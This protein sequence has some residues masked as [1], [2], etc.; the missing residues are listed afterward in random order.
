MQIENNVSLK[1]FNTFN[2]DVTAKYFADV[3][4]LSELKELLNNK[5]Y[6]TERR[7]FL[8]GGSNILFTKDFAGIIIK[9]NNSKIEKVYETD[10][11][12][13]IK[14]D[15][16]VEWDSFVKYSVDN[17]LSG[18]E[19][20]SLIPGCV[21]AAPIQNIGA[22]GVEVKDVIESVNIILLKNT[23]EKTL[24]NS[25]C[26]FQY[27]NSIFKSELKDKFVI[28][29]VVFKL[30]KQNKVNLTYSPLKNYFSRKSESDV[31]PND[32]RDAV[33]SIRTSKL[34]NPKLLGNAGSFFK[35]PII[36]KD[37]FAQFKNS[38]SEL[39]GY[40]ETDGN[41]KISAGWLIEKC[42]LKG[43]R[44]GDVGVHEKQALV[45]VNYGYAT[46]N[47]IVEFSKMIQ[48]DVK[49]KFNVRLINE[50]NIL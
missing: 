30:S 33:I 48:N 50:V 3:N 46:G 39:M 47:E 19:N 14:A 5:N 40:S 2:V 11:E 43:K 24:S 36:S 4:D 44:I 34:P 9:L 21:G 29:S 32:I 38:Y 42:G 8:G 1:P 41:I 37:L 49:N 23:E 7:L 35:N 20:L 22:Y 26:K 18:I 13:F 17:G 31:T 10:E 25:E 27:R 45:I 12:L 28:T 6:I 15:A 16:G